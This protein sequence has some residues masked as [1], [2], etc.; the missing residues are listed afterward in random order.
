MPRLYRRKFQKIG[1]YKN[2]CAKAVS[3]KMP[4]TLLALASMNASEVSRRYAAGERDFR[5]VKLQGQSFKGK[6]LSGADFS[7]ADIRGANFTDAVLKNTCFLRAKAGVQRRWVLG[8]LLLLFVIAALSGVLQG[9]FGYFVA[10]YFPRW[11]DSGYNWSNFSIDL[12]AMLA[13]STIIVTVFIAI[14]RQGY[15]VR[16]VGSIA[17]AFAVAFAIAGAVAGAV[18]V[19]VAFSGAVAVAVT[20]SVAIAGA[21]A[22]AFSG[23]YAIMFLI[24]ITVAIAGAVAVAGTVAVAGAFAVVGAG[25]GSVA[26][27][28]AVVVASAI[29]F[30]SVVAFASLVLGIYCSR[31]ALAGDKK[32]A[33]I[34]SFGVVVGALGGTRFYQADLTGANFTQAQLKGANVCEATL[35]HVCWAQAR[36]LD[37]A[38]VGESILADWAVCALLTSRNGYKKSYVNADFQGANLDGINLQDANLKGANL[39]LATLR[40]VNLRDANLREVLAIGAD[41][42]GAYLTGACLEA[43]NIDHTTTFKQVDCQYIFLLERPN[44]LGSR[45]RRPHEPDQVFGNGDFERL[46]TKVVNVVQVLLRNGMQNQTAFRE[47]FQALMDEYPEISADAIQAIERKGNDALVTL[48]VPEIVD[49]AEISRSLRAAHERVLHLE[50]KVERLQELRAAD[51]KEVAMAQKAQFFNQLVGGNAMNNSTDQSQNFNVGGDFKIDATNSV[52]NLRDINGTVTNAIAQIPESGNSD[53]PSLK[54]LLTQ[55][56][57]AIATDT[58]LPDKGKASALEQVNVLAEVAQTPDQPEKKA[59]GSQAITFLK[60]AASFLPDTAK[61]AEACAKLLPIITSLLGL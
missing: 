27:S 55:L 40:Q 57:E 33:L 32:F 42:T 14:A 26:F 44:T 29:A 45:E 2:N 51:L 19:A 6:D 54:D 10:A 52:V 28:S 3:G 8:Q 20:F 17:V 15:T 34:R 41:F 5:R 9:Y 47:A 25:A 58:D 23:A 30:S 59:L 18:A 24:A 56:Q 53:E 13:Y 31:R 7:E 22:V 46:Y 4:D 43:W 36:Q 37:W 35:T 21:G 1:V 11:W 61:L 50:A 38:R 12:A 60:G 49:K 16:A 48:E 39:S